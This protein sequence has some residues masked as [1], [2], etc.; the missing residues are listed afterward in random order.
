MPASPLPNRSSNKAAALIIVLAFVVLLTGLSL[1][2]FSRTTTERQLA[3]SSYNDTSSD[4]MARNALDI[5]VGNFKQEIVNG[6]ASP[7][8]SF[9][10]GSNVYYVYN[11]SPSP[12]AAATWFLNGAEMLA[13]VS[14]LIRRSVRNDQ[15]TGNPGLPSLASAVNSTTDASANGRSV[16]LARWN[17]HYLMPKGNTGNDDSYPKSPLGAPFNPYTPDPNGFTPP[18][19]VFVTGNGPTVITVPNPS[20]I[21]RYA[22]AVYD[23]GGLL[24]MNVAGY[25]TG[26]STARYQ[27]SAS[28]ARGLRLCGLNSHSATNRFRNGLDGSAYQVDKLVGWRNYATTQPTTTV[29]TPILR[30]ISRATATQALL[31]FTSIINNTNWFLE[32][33]PGRAYS[34]AHSWNNRTDQMFVQRQELIAFRAA[35]EFSSNALQYLSTFSRET[36]APS[37]SPATPTAIN[38]NFLLIRVTGTFTRFDGTSAVVGEPLVK[39]RFPLSRLAWITYKGS[40]CQSLLTTDPVYT[41]LIN[42]RR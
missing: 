16:T 30:R 28:V 6:S 18:D 32:F 21:G 1:A 20:V 31:Y 2:Y 24:D 25:P 15:L 14:N 17:T 40:E 9:G 19:W 29:P 22:Y 39:T 10:S 5:V 12:A 37:F 27:P 26:T 36:N 34:D 4:L 7:A 41:A 13:G 35:T 42:C 33:R 38:P 23:E 3:H 11:P 8:P